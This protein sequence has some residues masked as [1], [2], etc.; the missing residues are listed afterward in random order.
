M[1]NEFM[2]HVEDITFERKMFMLAYMPLLNVGTQK[3]SK[4]LEERVINCIFSIFSFLFIVAPVNF[5]HVTRRWWWWCSWSHVMLHVM[6]IKCVDV[7]NYEP[8]IMLAFF[9]VRSLNINFF[10]EWKINNLKIHLLIWHWLFSLVK[11]RFKKNSIENSA[12]SCCN[13]KLHFQSG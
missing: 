13:F 9:C 8:S 1:L 7:C 3:R 12:Y 2:E 4:G 6:T 10:A 5:Q 11:L